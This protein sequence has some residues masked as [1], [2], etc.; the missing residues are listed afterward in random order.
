MMGDY[1]IMSVDKEKLFA[2][3]KFRFFCLFLLLLGFYRK[4]YIL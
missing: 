2:G 3:W 1:N 4:I